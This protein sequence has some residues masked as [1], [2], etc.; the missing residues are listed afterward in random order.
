MRKQP[1]S[2]SCRSSAL[3]SDAFLVLCVQVE[4]QESFGADCTLREMQLSCTTTGATHSFSHYHYH[5][6]PD[7]GVPKTSSSIRTL[8]RALDPVR[9]SGRPVIVHCSAVSAACVA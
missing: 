8:C 3:W 7:H 2:Y 6:W 9:A 1:W 4:Q 5:S